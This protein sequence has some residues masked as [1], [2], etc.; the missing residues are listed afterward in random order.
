MPTSTTR[1]PT[2]RTRSWCASAPSGGTRAISARSGERACG[3]R[4]RAVPAS[5]ERRAYLRVR[6][7]LSDGRPLPLAAAGLAGAARDPRVVVDAT[8]LAHLEDRDAIRATFA[9]VRR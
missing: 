1:G 9:R 7:A 3:R 4:G 8:L 2:A 6:A 5:L